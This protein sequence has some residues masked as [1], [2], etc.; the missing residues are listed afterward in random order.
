MSEG[1]ATRSLVSLL[2]ALVSVLLSAG[3]AGANGPCGQNFDGDNACGITSPGTVSGSLVT[4]NEKDYYVLYARKGTELS[5]TVTD[6]ESPTCDEEFS[7]GSAAV[8]LLEGDGDEEY[9]SASSSP[10]HGITVPGDFDHTI[11]TTGTYYL[12]VSGDL[13]S[14]NND[15]PTP[16]PY[17]LGVNASPAVQWPPPAPPSPTHKV[18]RCTYR[19]VHRHGHAVRIKSCRTVVVAG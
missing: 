19:H 7:C 17:T 8:E 16:V 18:R 15:N 10:N 3:I 11:E 1:V 9:Q 5:V 2:V 4:D 13:G 14:D 12:V 6:T